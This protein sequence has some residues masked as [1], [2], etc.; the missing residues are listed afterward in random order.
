MRETSGDR[1]TRAQLA[2]GSRQTPLVRN[3]ELRHRAD[4]RDSDAPETSFLAGPVAP[5]IASLGRAF[6]AL[7]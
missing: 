4:G 5:V 2:G 1:G 7:P 3:V 6:W